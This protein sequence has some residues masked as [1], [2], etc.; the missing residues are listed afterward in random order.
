MVY[1][2]MISSM[3]FCIHFVFGYLS[4]VFYT[5]SPL[6]YISCNTLFSLFD[7]QLS[8]NNTVTNLRSLLKIR[9]SFINTF[10]D[11][12]V[13]I[14]WVECKAIHPFHSDSMELRVKVNV[15]SHCKKDTFV[16]VDGP[17]QARNTY[18]NCNRSINV[19]FMHTL[20]H[21]NFNI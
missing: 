11:G 8:N 16:T 6:R 14:V 18:Y 7:C 20:Y 13:F 5:I 9:K 12:F 2:Y 19:S 10:W 17:K 21:V 1:T 4:F 15:L 3:C